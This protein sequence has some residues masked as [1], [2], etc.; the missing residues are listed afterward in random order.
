MGKFHRLM[1]MSLE[2]AWREGCRLVLKTSGDRKV[3]GSTPP[4]SAK[5]GEC[6]GWL[7]NRPAKAWWPQGQSFD[8]IILR[9]SLL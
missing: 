6:L 3:R 8:A 1:P 9:Q 2:G 4:P 5:H 7:P